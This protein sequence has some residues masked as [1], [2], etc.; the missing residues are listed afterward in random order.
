[1]LNNL[2]RYMSFISAFRFKNVHWLNY[3]VV[4]QLEIEILLE[5]HH[6]SAFNLACL[7]KEELNVV[8]LDIF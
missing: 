7:T 1:M 3:D 8:Y 6:F 4:S 2:L 5:C